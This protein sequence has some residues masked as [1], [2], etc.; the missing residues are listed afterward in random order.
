MREMPIE[1]KELWGVTPPS[2]L[3]C[4]GSV[5]AAT[6][7]WLW[8][9]HPWGIALGIIGLCLIGFAIRLNWIKG[10]NVKWRKANFVLH[11]VLFVLSIAVLAISWIEQTTM[12]K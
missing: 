9:R 1:K 6:G 10:L 11:I 7:A 2:I 8:P 4:C 12:R 5:L 3:A